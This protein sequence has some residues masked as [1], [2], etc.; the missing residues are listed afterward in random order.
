M[1]SF[2]RR[3]I[4]LAVFVQGS[5][6]SGEEPAS[7]RAWL[8]PPKT[9]SDRDGRISLSAEAK[10]DFWRLTASGT[11][12]DSGHFYFEEREGDFTVTVKFRADY[13]AQYDQAGLMIRIDE[14]NWIKTGVEFLDGRGNIATVVTRDFSDGSTA[15]EKATAK[16]VWLKLTR[17]GD[18]VEIH[19]SLD[20]RSFQVVRQAYFPPKVACKVGVMA[21]APVG[22]GFKAIFEDL[23]ITVAQ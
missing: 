14:K 19:Y 9:W 17:K 16:P 13:A 10:S 6:T 11:A 1:K 18:F 15:P 7:K 8:N 23:K 5:L 2:T 21:A 20:N 3:L 12:A 4:V 22:T